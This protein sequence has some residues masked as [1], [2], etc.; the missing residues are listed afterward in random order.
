MMDIHYIQAN[1]SGNTTIFVLSPVEPALHS[2]VAA[3]LL[4]PD[5]VG[6]EQVGY[7]TMPT[8]EGQPIR[9][10]MMGGEFC[11]NAS[12]S[13]AA[14]ALLLSGKDSGTYTISC[15]GCDTLLTAQAAKL[16]DGLY[17]ASIEMPLPESV[18]AVLVDV[19]G[20]PSRFFR[21]ALP[22]IVH[23]VHFVGTLE[24]ADRQ[25]FWNAVY[26]YAK[27]D[28]LEAFGLVL[29]A[30]AHLRMIPAVYVT[31]TDT[32]YWEQSCG[33]GSAA[34][35]AALACMGKKNVSCTINQPGGAISIAADVAG[36]EKML[37]RFGSGGPVAFSAVR[38]V[39]SD[40]S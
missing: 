16:A 2:A 29:F 23:F 12:R 36:E 26:D 30:P 31:A 4:Q 10:D 3:K 38:H 9:V 35:A 34:V 20:M 24:E 18:E 25:V 33:S 8:A 15:S 14:Y 7:L 19:G 32:L 21:V 13:A 1:P 27:D 40:L 6:G 22:G 5:C 17:D 28:G 37:Q 11:G 39:A